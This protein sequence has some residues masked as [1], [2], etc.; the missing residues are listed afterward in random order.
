MKIILTLQAIRVI[1]GHMSSRR[2][3]VMQEDAVGYNSGGLSRV[4]APTFAPRA[5]AVTI[6]CG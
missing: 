5:H 2:R 1:P 4:L 6:I 3:V